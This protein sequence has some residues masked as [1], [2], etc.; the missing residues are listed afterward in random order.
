MAIS[1]TVPAGPFTFGALATGAWETLSSGS[2]ATASGE[3]LYYYTTLDISKKL[4]ALAVPAG[5]TMDDNGLIS[6]TVTPGSYA[7]VVVSTMYAT[8]G[9]TI[10]F[11]CVRLSVDVTV[12]AATGT[13]TGTGT[14]T[15]G[16]TTTPTQ[17]G[18]VPA[19]KDSTQIFTNL[20]KLNCGQTFYL[21][22]PWLNISSAE[23]LIGALP[24][25]LTGHDYYI[26]DPGWTLS[27]D[28]DPAI[29]TVAV[30]PW[31]DPGVDGEGNPLTPAEV[32]AMVNVAVA[33]GDQ[34][35]STQTVQAVSRFQVQRNPAAT[36]GLVMPQQPPWIDAEVG[37]EI[38][39]FDL[40]ALCPGMTLELTAGPLPPGLSLD[41][42][43]V[44]EAI[45]AVI[46]GAPVVAVSTFVQFSVAVPRGGTAPSAFFWLL[47]TVA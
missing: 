6:G 30:P 31:V 16:G 43:S 39:P 10:I 40:T 27:S 9:N 19:S 44:G 3:A 20:P 36:G 26:A 24:E 5:C 38:A 47:I 22:M 17:I 45:H 8:G 25:T 29:M 46:R 15:T 41:Y 13:G 11:N 42:I 34:A 37:S 4:H 23:A 2:P 7:I 32:L 12:T 33:T 18:L 14:G 28:T 35:S 21:V 1:I